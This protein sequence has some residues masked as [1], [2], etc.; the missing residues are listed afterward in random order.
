[1][2]DILPD[3]IEYAPLRTWGAEGARVGLTICPRCGSA[4]LIDPDD[5]EDRL[6][7]HTAWHRRVES[8]LLSPA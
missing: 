7:Q 3:G 4:L 2:S 8:Q 1:M 5:H 6:A